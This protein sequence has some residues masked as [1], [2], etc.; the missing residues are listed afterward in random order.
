[1]SKTI[2]KRM[3]GI[4]KTFTLA[5]VAASTVALGA[6]PAVAAPLRGV[7]TGAVTTT[8]RTT[9]TQATSTQMTCSVAIEVAKAYIA[10]GDAMMATDNVSAGAAFYG[11]ADGVLQA[12][13]PS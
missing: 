13:C 12:A 9:S 4:A 3:L 10:A 7:S 2:T 11:R 1:M 6:A 8:T 5:A